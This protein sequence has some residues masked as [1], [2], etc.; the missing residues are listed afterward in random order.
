MMG[1]NS[2]SISELRKAENL[3][4]LSLIIQA[5]L[6]DAFCVFRL[7]DEAVEQSKKTLELDQGFA[8]GH[9]ELDWR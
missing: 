5:D 7:Y 9:Y 2:E 1:Q 4:P 8:V 6:A 3:D